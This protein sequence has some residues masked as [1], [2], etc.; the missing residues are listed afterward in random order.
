VYLL[1]TPLVRWL[2]ARAVL[3]LGRLLGELAYACSRKR[4]AV[5]LKNL[6]IA[7]GDSKT[8]AEK[9]AIARRAFVQL[10][11]SGLQCWWLSYDPAGRIGQLIEEP[12]EGLDELQRCL[13]QQKGVFFL[14]AHYG[15][16]EAMGVHH[17]RLGIAP[18]H[19][20]ARRLD[21]PYLEALALRLRTASGNGIFYREDS[22]LK[23]VRA[24]QRNHCVAVM[25]DQN[26]ARGAI[27]TDFFGAPAATARSIAVLKYATGA[28]ILPLFSYPTANGAYKIRYGPELKL[29]KSA[30][31]ENDIQR[32]TQAC[33]SYLESVI[34]EYP[35]P[36]MWGHRRWKTR[37][38]EERGTKLYT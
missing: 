17:G 15:N 13:A 27:F 23:I 26:A 35:E 1:F 28:P 30:D 22:P 19:S 37:P 18:L 9:D 31:K 11:V 20:I 36:W 33:E 25:M 10:A 7:F 34:R 24:L 4:K 14:T 3:R 5:A 29:E 12:T 6:S 21:N 32:W 2:T 16:W 8:P 38:P